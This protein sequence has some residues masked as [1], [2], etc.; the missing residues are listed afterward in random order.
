MKSSSGVERNGELERCSRGGMGRTMGREK[1]RKEESKMYPY[2]VLGWG[3]PGRVAV[4]P[5][6]L[7]DLEAERVWRG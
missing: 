5:T 1:M 7:G 6:H 2:S 4:L 3:G